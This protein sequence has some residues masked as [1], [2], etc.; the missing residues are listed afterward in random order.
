MDMH[1]AYREVGTYRGAAEICGTTPKTVKRIGR[2]R[3]AAEEAGRTRSAPQLRR[4]ARPGGRAGRPDQGPDHRRSGCCRWP[5]A[6]GYER[7]GPELPPAGGRGE[8]RMAAEQPPGSPPGVWAPGEVLVD[9]LGGDRAPARVLRGARPGAGAGSC[10]SLT[11]GA[12]DDA[13]GAGG[14]LRALGGVPKIVLA[15]RMGCLK[16]GVVA[17]LVIPTPDYVRFATHYGFRA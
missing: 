7:F 4:R 17:K 1:A 12:G 6:A 8:D 14:V 16:G 10:V 2:G 9:R 13:G 11:T 15:D 5:K 3:R